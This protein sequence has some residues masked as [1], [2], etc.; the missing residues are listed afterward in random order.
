MGF[1]SGERT[2]WTWQQEEARQGQV[3]KVGSRLGA[4]S[5]PEDVFKAQV[6]RPSEPRTLG[7]SCSP[8]SNTASEQNQQSLRPGFKSQPCRLPACDLRASYVICLGLSLLICTVGHVVRI[9]ALASCMWP[10]RESVMSIPL[11]PH[12]YTLYKLF[13][14]VEHVCRKFAL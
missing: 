10:M 4:L 12:A 2:D 11:H 6:L 13:I 3:L 5:P 1:Q 8:Y 14:K 7:W 9:G